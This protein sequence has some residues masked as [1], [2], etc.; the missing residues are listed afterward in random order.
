MCVCDLVYTIPP[1]QPM[2]V[3]IS[4]AV[5]TDAGATDAA[6]FCD[7]AAEAAEIAAAVAVDAGDAETP[8][9]LLLATCRVCWPRW[10]WRR[11]PV[12]AP[13]ERHLGVREGVT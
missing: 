9:A 7:G 11:F 2:F 4:A 6:E 8:A 12:T 1:S 5:E 10:R 13:L 3:S